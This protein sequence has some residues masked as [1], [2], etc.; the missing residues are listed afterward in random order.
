MITPFEER[1]RL[2]VYYDERAI[3]GTM[4]GDAGVFL[5]A[6]IK[7]LAKHSAKSAEE[8]ITLI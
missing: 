5:R 2:F 1:S 3:E 8:T 7:S 4:D 6:G